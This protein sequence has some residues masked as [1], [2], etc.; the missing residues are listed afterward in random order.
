[1]L[2]CIPCC[3]LKMETMGFI[4]SAYGLLASLVFLL[5]ALSR[6]RSGIDFG[7]FAEWTLT[8]GFASLGLGYLLRYLPK[9]FIL[10][11]LNF[12]AHPLTILGA[13]LLALHL[14]VRLE[15][16]SRT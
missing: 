3:D 12:A 8:L 5:L 4:P 11:F 14:T 16:L 10:Y 15:L 6:Y 7:N 9:F 1:M 2:A 13:L